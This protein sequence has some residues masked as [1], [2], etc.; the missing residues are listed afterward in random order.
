MPIDTNDLMSA[1]P[2]GMIMAWY[3]KAGL[4]PFGWVVCDGTNETPDLRG[5]FLMGAAGSS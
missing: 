4:I 3:A 1:F 5:K 2:K